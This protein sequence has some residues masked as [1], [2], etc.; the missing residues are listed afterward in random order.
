MQTLFQSVCIKYVIGL[1]LQ[2]DSESSPVLL[3]T[4]RGIYQWF[5]PLHSSRVFELAWKM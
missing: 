2:A 3:V 1:I 5:W 4:F